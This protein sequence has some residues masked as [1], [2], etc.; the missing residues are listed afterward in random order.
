MPRSRDHRAESPNRAAKGKV[1]PPEYLSEQFDFE[2]LP[3]SVTRQPKSLRDGAFLD[4]RESAILTIHRSHRCTLVHKVIGSPAAHLLY[5]KR[6]GRSVNAE[7]DGRDADCDIY[8]AE[9]DPS[10]VQTQQKTENYGTPRWWNWQTQG[11]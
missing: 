6:I 10:G 1:G 4:R 7:K 3:L 5:A 11:T 8:R 2:R 9:G